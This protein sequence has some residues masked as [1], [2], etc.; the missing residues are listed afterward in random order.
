MRARLEHREVRA[1]LPQRYPLLLVDQVVELRAGESIRTRKAI[2]GTE[3]CYRALADGTAPESYAYPLSLMVESLGQSAALLWLEGGGEVVDESSALLF[4]GARG[5]RLLGAAYPGD[6]LE[7]TVELENVIA[8]TVFARG[9]SRVGDR[10]VLTA[11]SLIAAR[12][13]RAAMGQ[14]PDARNDQRGM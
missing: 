12:R 4:T 7:H 8:E 3:P 2:S 1:K 14:L 6:V 13:P 11:E 9:V 5:V 10:T